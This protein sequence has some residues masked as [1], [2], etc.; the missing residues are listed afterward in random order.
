MT[1]DCSFSQKICYEVS[2]DLVKTGCDFMSTSFV[3]QHRWSSPFKTQY[4]DPFF[5]SCTWLVLSKILKL[6][7]SARQWVQ[8]C[9]RVIHCILS[10]R[11][12]CYANSYW[13]A[14]V[15]TR[16]STPWLFMCEPVAFHQQSL[17]K[18]TYSQTHTCARR[19][20]A[21]QTY[22]RLWRNRR[23]EKHKKETKRNK[24]QA[25]C[26]IILSEQMHYCIQY[27]VNMVEESELLQLQIKP[28]HHCYGLLILTLAEIKRP[29]HCS[30]PPSL[31]MS[32]IPLP[33]PQCLL[34]PVLSLIPHKFISFS[35][36][37][38]HLSFLPPLSLQIKCL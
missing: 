20:T 30:I 7:W 31:P 36:P 8:I 12:T 17:Q 14:L 28:I 35:P 19:A 25:T 10:Y 3:L 26:G 27:N 22:N 4:S 29:R 18:V 15:F 37:L 6:T 33:S 2:W 11:V 13:P 34:S 32:C 9:S 24:A 23:H 38:L 16:M 1:I 21:T 5:W